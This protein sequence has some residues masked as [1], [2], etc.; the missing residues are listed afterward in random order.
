MYPTTNNRF[1]VYPTHL[2]SV[3]ICEEINDDLPSFEVP[4][5]L[6]IR[7]LR[8]DGDYSF[9]MNPSGPDLIYFGLTPSESNGLGVSSLILLKCID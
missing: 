7:K 1:K 8:I 2:S 5:R 6:M 4:I 9:A 3:Y